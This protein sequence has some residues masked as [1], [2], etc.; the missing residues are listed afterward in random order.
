MF[1][2]LKIIDLNAVWESNLEAIS[3][4][5][6]GSGHVIPKHLVGGLNIIK[7][8]SLNGKPT[9]LCSHRNLRWQSLAGKW[10]DFAVGLS[11]MEYVIW[12]WKCFNNSCCWQSCNFQPNSSCYIMGIAHLDKGI[13]GH[14][15]FPVIPY[16]SQ[17]QLSFQSGI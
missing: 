9:N 3:L 7:G 8:E 17:T 12:D 16:Y 6:C 15:L 11:H 10:L 2:I 14:H 13:Q 5:V 1:G 4:F